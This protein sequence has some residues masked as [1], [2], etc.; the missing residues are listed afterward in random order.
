[1]PATQIEDPRTCAPV[2]IVQGG[3][4]GHSLAQ[5]M[6]ISLSNCRLRHA[7]TSGVAVE[8][9]GALLRAS[10]ALNSMRLYREHLA[11]G[12]NETA[13]SCRKRSARLRY[14]SKAVATRQQVVVFPILAEAQKHEIS[15]RCRAHGSCALEVRLRAPEPCCEALPRVI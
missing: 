14:F 1:M 15:A 12:Q 9:D 2:A 8:N 7:G 6:S 10:E 11:S 4:T 13:G 3:R 5:E